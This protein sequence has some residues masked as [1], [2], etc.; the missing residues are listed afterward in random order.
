MV[1][2]AHAQALED[3]GGVGLGL[4]ATQLGI[5]GLELGGLDAV[6]IGEVLLLIEGVH[7]LADVVEME[8]AHENRFHDGIGVILVL[9]LLQHGHADVGQDGHLTGGGVQL[10]GENLQKGGF[11]RPVGSYN[12]IAVALHKLKVHMGKERGSGIVEGKVS[13]G[14]HGG[15]LLI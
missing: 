12:A 1:L 7:L 9:V 5:L 2:G 13:N 15:L 4:I 11:P 14:D 3:P 6:L 10:P 8:V